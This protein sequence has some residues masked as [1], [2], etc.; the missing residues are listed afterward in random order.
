MKVPAIIK[1]LGTVGISYPS[2]DT[3]YGKYLRQTN[4]IQ[5]TTKQTPE[6]AASTLAHELLHHVFEMSG[7][8]AVLQVLGNGDAI[9]EGIVTAI[10][11]FLFKTK[12][13]V[14][15]KDAVTKWTNVEFL[16]DDNDTE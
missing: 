3:Y 11:N 6:Q 1:T 4:K 2:M 13:F 15:N 12:V 5:V 16:G 7:Q 9:E 10:E 14:L 8:G